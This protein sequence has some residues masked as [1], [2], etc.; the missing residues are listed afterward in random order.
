MSEL[1]QVDDNYYRLNNFYAA[2]TNILDFIQ[3]NIVAGDIKQTLSQP[4]QLAVSEQEAIRLFGY[5]NNRSSV[6]T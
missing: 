5:S 1:V 3:L 6:K 2:T 4:G